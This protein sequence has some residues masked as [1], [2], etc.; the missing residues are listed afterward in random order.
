MKSMY[1]TDDY[2]VV[3]YAQD[4]A[5]Y[6]EIESKRPEQTVDEDIQE[7]NSD[8]IAYW[9]DGNDYPQ[10]IR[11][12]LGKNSDL[13]SFLDL[14]ARVL[15]AGGVGYELQNPSTGE[16][17]P[18]RNMEIEAFLFRNW[19]YPIEATI[20]FYK[21]INVFPEI[22]LS[23]DRSKVKW[24][25]NRP[26]HQ[27]RYELQDKK[28]R[29]NNC[30]VSAN[31]PETLYNDKTTLMRPVIDAAYDMPEDVKERR[32]NAK[33]YIYPVSYYSGN[34]YY[35]LANWNS[36]R[37][38]KWLELANKI[39]AF[40]LAMMNN[41]ISIKYHIQIPDYY[42][43]WK[44]EGVWDTMSPEEKKGKKQEE[45]EAINTFLQGEKNA[46]KS[47]T[48]GYKVTIDGKELPGIKI[49]AIDDK[50]KDGIY[51][52]DS[53]EATI[54]MFSALGLDPSILG[55]VPGKGGSNRSGSDKREAI[56]LYI[57]IIQPHADVLLRPYNFISWYNGWNNENQMVRWYFKA[58]L[59]QTLDKV[60]PSQRETIPSEPTE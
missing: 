11:E 15:Y 43:Q 36:L 23:N 4:G 30:Y 55:I 58:P 12:E 17:I 27:C 7:K 54:K 1:A 33:N 28:G 34:T 48:T 14:Q 20:D 26:A 59:M 24:L 9:G 56:N 47:I 19:R 22:I 50:L 2:S 5:L 32:D 53:V 3:V 16:V 35:Q 41:Q 42:W 46:G 25:I 6:E 29:I 51:L 10:I 60:T 44:F 21:F 45:I 49:I 38:S 37:K 8:T 57:S 39:P 18:G 31:W 13:I 52:E 40:K